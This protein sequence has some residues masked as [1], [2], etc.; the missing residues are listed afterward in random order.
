MRSLQWLVSCISTLIVMAL[1]VPGVIAATASPIEETEASHLLRIAGHIEWPVDVRPQPGASIVVGVVGSAGVYDALIRMAQGRT[2][3][4]RA[5]EVIQLSRPEEAAH[6]HLLFVGNGAWEQLAAWISAYRSR[7]VV[8]AT[9]APQAVD[10]GATIGF[11]RTGQRVA[12]EASLPA[13][14][15]AGVKLSSDVLKVADRVVGSRP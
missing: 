1:L 5:I 8:V 4:G 6:V 13:A 2:V 11:V 10:R 12:I 14:E 7:P 15:Q 3:S 9:N